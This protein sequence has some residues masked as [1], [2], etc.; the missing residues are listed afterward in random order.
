MVRVVRSLLYTVTPLFILLSVFGA[1]GKGYQFISLIAAIVCLVILM[2]LVAFERP[3][4][5]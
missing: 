2:F 1:S 5:E 3:E 4:Q